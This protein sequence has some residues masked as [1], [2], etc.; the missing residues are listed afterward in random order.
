MDQLMHY[1]KDD[2][3]IDTTSI[4]FVCFITVV[5]IHLAIPPRGVLVTLSN[6][7]NCLYEKYF[8]RQTLLTAQPF[9]NWENITSLQQLLS[10]IAHEIDGRQRALRNFKHFTKGSFPALEKELNDNLKSLEED[11]EHQLAEQEASASIIR[12][13]ID[14]LGINKNVKMAQQS[15]RESRISI[16]ESKRVKVC[17]SIK[18]LKMLYYRVLWLIK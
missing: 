1:N 17:K 6:T 16:Q 9:Y 15:I 12:Q 13:Q 8:T 7:S 11:Y 2:R 5:K 18:L 10:V 14:M 4:L 3:A